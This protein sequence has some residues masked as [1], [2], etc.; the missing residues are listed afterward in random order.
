[1]KY[2]LLGRTG[3]NVSDIGYGLWGMSGLSGSEDEQSRAS[4]RAVVELG[5]NFFDSAWAYGDGKSDGFLGELLRDN[6]GQRL[7][8]ASKVP[9]MNLKWPASSR[10]SYADV[11][12]FH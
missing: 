5:F 9:P 4:L 11:F 3:F 7:Y 6:Q 12:P 8:A 1:M 2:R 10:D